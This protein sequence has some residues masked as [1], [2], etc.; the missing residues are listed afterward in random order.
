M[1]KFH[2]TSKWIILQITSIW[3]CLLL[4]FHAVEAFP[5]SKKIFFPE[6]DLPKPTELQDGQPL[7]DKLFIMRMLNLLE[8][9]SVREEN[10]PNGAQWVKDYVFEGDIILQT[11]QALEFVNQ[12]NRR[13]KRKLD[14]EVTSS[15]AS[16]KWTLPINYIFDGTHTKEQRAD[17]LAGI[18]HWEENTCIT[19]TNYTSANVTK[20][21][22]FIN[23]SG[24]YS[25][26]GSSPGT[27]EQVISI[28][29]NCTRKGIVAHEIGHALGFWHEHARADREDYISLITNN[30]QIGQLHNFDMVSWEFINNLGVPYDLGS[31]MH[32]S[33]QQFGKGSEQTIRTNNKLLQ[34][35]IGQREELSFFDVKLA[36]KAYCDKICNRTQLTDTCLHDGYQ[37]PKNCSTCR[38]PV[39]LSG[40]TC[41]Q[42]APSSDRCGGDFLL[43]SSSMLT[44]ESPGY[45]NN[46][47]KGL[48]CNWLIQSPA[49]TVIRIQFKEPF[50]QSEYCNPE[51]PYLPC[52]DYVEVRFT[53]SLGITGGRFCCDDAVQRPVLSEPII[54]HT[55]HALVIFKSFAPGSVGFRAE[56]TIDSCGGCH[57]TV[58]GNQSACVRRT[59][60]ECYQTWYKVI[61]LNSCIFSF[62]GCKTAYQ[63]QAVQRK[64]LCY[65]ESP[66]CCPGYALS[67][68]NKYCTSSTAQTSVNSNT[69]VSNNNNNNNG[70]NSI[71]KESD[72][73]E[74]AGWSGWT[75]WSS[76]SVTC[77]G[78]G[79]QIRS[80]SCNEGTV[81]V[82]ENKQTQPC[83]QN[84][85][86][87]GNVQQTCAKTSIKSKPCPFF[88]IGASTCYMRTT[89]YY[90]QTRNCCC[91]Y[92]IQNGVCQPGAA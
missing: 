22:K 90:T 38:C 12:N 25:Y 87:Y 68:D 13:R 57:N 2:K 8:R 50:M 63:T 70:S 91:G 1:L 86:N 9:R 75:A 80:R 61:Q 78:C 47:A 55:N 24:C 79:E 16:K 41:Q 40:T 65:S 74:P 34:H 62:W 88:S 66:Y 35:T 83:G 43:N 21:I 36:N 64:T 18:R 10:L 84:P 52:E 67:Q 6:Q 81:C 82:G 54:T 76:C 15:T 32:Y 29:E 60:V 28:G 4:E 56:V 72:Q 26:V 51:S 45:P 20:S 44:V 11:A 89:E 48:T 39:G 92:Q 42:V 85:C 23:D 17:I 33:G 71:S 5:T 37:D 3:V 31:V 46:Y 69:T 77:G 59:T 49:G 19:F 7:N 73:K 30:I 27:K 58:T 53:D 14:A